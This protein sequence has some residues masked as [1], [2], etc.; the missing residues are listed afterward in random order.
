MLTFGGQPVI[1]PALF[2]AQC[3]R[4]GLDTSWLGRANSYRCPIGAKPGQGWV[5][6]SRLDYGLLEEDGLHDLAFALAPGEISGVRNLPRGYRDGL[7]IKSL[8]VVGTASLTP[9]LRGDGGEVLLLQL[10]DRRWLYQNLPINLSYNVPEVPSGDLYPATI[11]GGVT[12]YTWAQVGQDL[13]EEVGT[14][15]LGAWPGLP[16]TPHGTPTNLRYFG[17]SAIAALEE[18]LGRLGCALVWNPTTDAFSIS[19]LGVEDADYEQFLADWDAWRVHDAD[20]L[21]EPRPNVPENVRVLFRKIPYPAGESPFFAVDVA[22]PDEYLADAARA[23]AGTCHTVHDDLPLYYDSGGTPQNSS[24]V[25]DR[26]QERAEDYARVLAC[27]LDMV[28]RTFALHAADPRAMPGARVW[29]VEWHDHGSGFRTVLRRT[30]LDWMRQFRVPELHN[31][32]IDTWTSS[33]PAGATVNY[34]GATI[35]VAGASTVSV[36]GTTTTTYGSSTSTTYNGLLVVQGP[37]YFPHHSFASWTSNQ[38]NLSLSGIGNV[39]LRIASDQHYR[40][41]R[42]IAPGTSPSGRVIYLHNVG[43]YVILIK[44]QDS[45]STA[46]NRIITTTGNDFFLSPGHAVALVYDATDSRWRVSENSDERLGATGSYLLV[47]DVNDAEMPRDCHQVRVDPDADGWI[48]TGIAGGRPGLKYNLLNGDSAY[49]FILSHSDVT[50][51]AANRFFLPNG[52]N[53]TIPPHAACTV[54]YDGT[55]ER[56]RL[57]HIPPGLKKFNGARAYCSGGKTLTNADEFY[58]IPM[59]TETFDTDAFHDNATNN[60]RVTVPS[61]LPGYYRITARWTPDWQTPA[62]SAGVL[63][64]GRLLLNG[65]TTLDQDEAVAEADAS[66]YL[67]AVRLLSA[68]DYVELQGLCSSAGCQ[69]YT[70]EYRTWITMEFLGVEP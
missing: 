24:D 57:H 31:E 66:T 19:R 33:P 70:E 28:Q 44:H 16:F 9:G 46:A 59:A 18:F 43:N 10:A 52:E 29:D 41:L 21:A 47:S 35:N 4:Q 37:L 32:E 17:G 39:R 22:T 53:V 63:F 48:I 49:S 3:V 12:A 11:S 14:S 36:G 62:L 1:D 27:G 13:W 23:E 34:T 5:L 56:W 65:A 42:S 6:M 26:A 64:Q 58:S 69:T 51:S 38:T 45:G 8:L 20:P 7:T 61:G 67:E 54:E 15:R 30:P 40:E 55:S 68:T 60:T 2:R 50:S 25:N